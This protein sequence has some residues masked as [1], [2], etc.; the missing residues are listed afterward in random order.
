M[1]QH[2]DHLLLTSLQHG[3]RGVQ[4]DY[5]LD[6]RPAASY[7]RDYRLCSATEHGGLREGETAILQAVH[8]PSPH[9]RLR[10]ARALRATLRAAISPATA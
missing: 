2:Q 10:A 1:L 3:S 5:A 8:L 9:D 6:A 4:Q 7:K